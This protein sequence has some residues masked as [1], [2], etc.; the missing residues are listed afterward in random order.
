MDSN[1]KELMITDKQRSLPINLEEGAFFQEEDESKAS[2]L[3]RQID[4]KDNFSRM[5]R[6]PLSSRLGSR[7]DTLRRDT[8]TES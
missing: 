5:S 8:Q 6:E 1:I 4:C 2:I 3:N 7:N